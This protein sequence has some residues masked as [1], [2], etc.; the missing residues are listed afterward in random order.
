MTQAISGV[1]GELAIMMALGNELNLGAKET[2]IEQAEE[3]LASLLQALASQVSHDGG[4]S[5]ALE[6]FIKRFLAAEKG[7]PLT[8]AEGFA[9]NS[10]REMRVQLKKDDK[11]ISGAN[12]AITKDNAT[13]AKY[14]ND[15]NTKNY[16]Y[17]YRKVTIGSDWDPLCWISPGAASGAAEALFLLH[18]A[19]YAE[20]IGNAA[21]DLKNQTSILTGATKNET[22]IEQQF[23][24]TN[25]AKAG[26]LNSVAQNSISVEHQISQ[27][28][29]SYL[30]DLLFTEA[31]VNGAGN[32]S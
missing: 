4:S 14:N 24:G 7:Q 11:A 1:N 10:L 9:F 8:A 5:T 15:L 26:S 30:S 29:F 2:A 18:K 20:N 13:I 17:W 21:T 28:C 27:S 22:G 3:Y 25:N 32:N 6:E 19:K 31:A 23:T 16:D 12:T